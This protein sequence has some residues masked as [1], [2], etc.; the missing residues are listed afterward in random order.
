MCGG[1][2]V[3]EKGAHRG[4]DARTAGR[5]RADTA[6]QPAKGAQI[7]CLALDYLLCVYCFGGLYVKRINFYLLPGTGLLFYGMYLKPLLSVLK[8]SKLPNTV[9][10]SERGMLKCNEHD[11]CGKM[12]WRIEPD[13]F[14]AHTHT[15]TPRLLFFF[16]NQ[17]IM[18]FNVLCRG[19]RECSLEK[20]T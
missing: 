2:G 17:N 6:S 8:W 9:Q 14:P 20:Y 15:H 5:A 11:W 16:T 13:S 1:A 3:R 12:R 18:F 7:P 19:P 4:Q 10:G